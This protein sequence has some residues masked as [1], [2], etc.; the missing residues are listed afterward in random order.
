MKSNSDIECVPYFDK[1]T[2][3]QDNGELFWL[4][5]HYSDDPRAEGLPILD[6]TTEDRK[7]QVHNL[8]TYMPYKDGDIE[9]LQYES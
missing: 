9:K 6:L 3:S 5:L 7:W 1:V 8:G 2:L 4:F